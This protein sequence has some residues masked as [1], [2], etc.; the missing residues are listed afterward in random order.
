MDLASERNTPFEIEEYGTLNRSL[1]NAIAD[2]VTK[3]SQQH[4]TQA[5]NGHRSKE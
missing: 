3:F 5:G 1:D 4:D 2:A